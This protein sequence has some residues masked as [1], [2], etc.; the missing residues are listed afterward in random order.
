MAMNFN[1][2]TFVR[3]Q[4]FKVIYPATIFFSPR[5]KSFQETNNLFYQNAKEERNITVRNLKFK[6]TGELGSA[7]VFGDELK[8]ELIQQLDAAIVSR[9]K[10]INNKQMFLIHC[11]GNASCYETCL[12]QYIDF[13]SA[14]YNVIGFNPMGVG[15]S[16]G[17]TN[18]PEDY[19]KAAVAVIENLLRNG[20]P[21]E[22]IV[23]SGRSLGAAILTSVAAKYIDKD[24]NL[25][26]INDRS[27]A[28]LD[29]ASAGYVQ[30]LIPTQLLRNTLGV[31][32]YYLS[33]A[34]INLFNLNINA[35]AAFTK[36]NSSN[37]GNAVCLCVNDDKIINEKSSLAYNLSTEMQKY[38]K[39]FICDDKSSHNA[40][41]YTMQGPTISLTDDTIPEK[42][43]MK[44]RCKSAA[45]FMHECLKHCYVGAKKE[46]TRRLVRALIFEL[47][48]A[49]KATLKANADDNRNLKLINNLLH[50][51]VEKIMH[52]TSEIEE[53]YKNDKQFPDSNLHD[54]LKNL[55]K[56]SK[57]IVKAVNAKQSMIDATIA[58]N[59][60]MIA[61]KNAIAA[62]EKFSHPGKA[63]QQ[64]IKSKAV[65]SQLFAEQ[66][67]REVKR[68]ERESDVSL[69]RAV[70]QIEGISFKIK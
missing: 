55:V 58:S 50:L 37:P 1:P 64:Q 8:N 28:R 24:V 7:G 31:F 59:K 23:L 44:H 41:I 16:K 25:K 32:A 60:A 66:M 26:V 68:L 15:Y 43:I 52:I 61:A 49:I 29:T 45:D 18:G 36:I 20:V 42:N 10:E 53:L 35:A 13:A 3:R 14:G 11:D 19:E 2:Y 17:L 27:F 62:A 9:A 48:G 51:S 65:Q 12:Y 6:V 63:K 69:K 33:K 4:I 57:D 47:Q 56:I 40:S 46:K 30:N 39:K 21:P 70:E 22:N 5:Y 38:A 54:S 34:L 67:Q